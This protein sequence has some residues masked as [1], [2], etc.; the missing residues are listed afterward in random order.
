MKQF[1][2]RTRRGRYARLTVLLTVLVIAVTV[3]ANAVFSTLADRY[4]WYTQMEQWGEYRISDACFTVL[5]GAI[6]SYEGEPIDLIFC[7]TEENIAA[8]SMLAYLYSTATALQSR[9]SDCIRIH[10]YD[11]I[12]NPT[13]VRNFSTGTNPITGE[14][15]E[16]DLAETSVVVSCGSYYR[17]YSLTEFFSYKGNDTSTVWAY[18]G[19]RKL[20]SAVLRALHPEQ[21]M[22]CMTENH[23]EVYYDYELLEL[24]DDAGYTISYLDLQSDPIPETCRLIISYNPNTDLVNDAVSETSEA[25]ILNR[26]LEQSGNSFLLFLDSTSPS[27]PNYE[28]F[29]NEW[30]VSCRYYQDA[31]TGKRYRYSVQ[32]A[33]HSLTSDGCTVYADPVRT[34][35]SAVLSEGLTER[36]VFQ[37]ATALEVANGYVSN[38]DGSFSQLSGNRTMYA[39][40][41]SSDSATSWAN[42]KVRDGGGA[43]LM[44]FTEETSAD[45]SSFVGVIASTEFSTEDFLQSAVYEN[46]NILFRMLRNMGKDAVPENLRIKPFQTTEISTVT[47]VEKLYWTIGLVLTP[48]VLVTAVAVVVLIRRRYKQ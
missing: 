21:T 9:Y 4:V 40:Y 27:L 2:T 13:T 3:L 29:L 14:E 28:D 5:D 42:G 7:D 26:F 16:Y 19:E 23:G 6:R 18:N 22:V 38:G 44:S 1:F 36:A 17:V 15:M 33:A 25:V 45:G 35:H 8:D 10:C 32:D 37:N 11:I 48:A 43:I 12:L 46:G 31:E 39:L 41:E 30:G 47:T 24:L 34:G 20:V